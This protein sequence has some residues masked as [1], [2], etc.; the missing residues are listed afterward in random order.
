[1]IMV[2]EITSTLSME[3][4]ADELNNILYEKG[5]DF[6]VAYVKNW[7]N[8]TVLEGYTLKSDEFNC[9]PTV[10]YGDWY[11]QDSD[12]VVEYLM[13]LYADTATDYD[14]KQVIS[15]EYICQNALPKLISA[16]NESYVKERD[17]AYIPFLDMLITFY[18]PINGLPD[19]SMGS[20]QLTEA[21]LASVELTTEELRKIAF[22]NLEEHVI[23]QPINEVISSLLGADISDIEMPA[24]PMYV[25]TNKNKIFGAPA[26]L[27]KKALAELS[28][29]LGERS[30]KLAI[31]PSSV[32][33]IIAVPYNSDED[34]DYMID[35]VTEINA[36]EVSL[37][38]KLTDNVYTYVGGEL[39]ALR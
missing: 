11:E 8:N 21:L 14:I 36:T 27:S 15:K 35:M 31:L 2:K 32:H 34:L 30:N 5:A 24:L 26:M 28:E 7:K 38:D 1:M 22:D 13:S 29:M 9:L 37:E 3:E 16:T 19:D 6:T 25:L 20:I 39:K 17:L 4:R 33:E 23:V 18:V 12:A 10:Y